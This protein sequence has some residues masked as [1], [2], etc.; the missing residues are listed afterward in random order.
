MKE[1]IKSIKENPREFVE[2][3]VLMSTLS[4]LFYVSIWIFY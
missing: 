1:F 4:I 2:T 3:V